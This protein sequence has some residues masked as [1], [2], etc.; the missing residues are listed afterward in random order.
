MSILENLNKKEFKLKLKSGNY[1]HTVDVKVSGK[2]LQLNFPYNPDL[3]NEVKT[4]FEGRKWLG[5]DDGPKAWQIPISPRNLFRLEVMSGKYTN[6]KPYK[7]FDEAAT[8]DCRAKILK[9]VESRNIN[10]MEHQFQMIS[11]ALI[12]K[13]F[14]WAAEMGLGKTLCSIIVM[15]MSGIQDWFWVAPRSAL[16]SAEIDFDKWK[17]KIRPRFMTYEGLKTIIEN[18]PV[19][20]PPPQG[21]IFDEV[22]RCKTPTAKRTIAAKYLADNMRM[23]YGTD[24]IIGGLS[25]TPAPKSPAD[26]WSLCELICPGFIKEGTIF[27]FRERLALMEKKE[28]LAGAGAYNALVT[29][30]D[31]EEKCKHCGQLKEHKNH[32]KADFLQSLSTKQTYEIHDWEPSVNEVA[33]LKKR[34][35]GLVGVWRKVDCLDLPL[36]RYEVIRV[37]PTR[38][39]KNAATIIA[40]TARRSVDA[41]TLLR[42][43]S[44]GFQY[45]D[46]PT[47]NML[48]CPCCNGKKEVIEYVDQDDPDNPL[49][50]DECAEQMRFVWSVC[51]PEDDVDIFIPE[52]IQKLPIT[53]VPRSVTCNECDGVGEV[54]EMHRVTHEVPCPKDQV[55]IDM[56]ERH[57]EV[58]R[59]NIYAGFQGSVDRVVKICLK[60]GWDVVRADGRGWCGFTTKGLKIETSDKELMKLYINDFEN[61]PQMVFVGQPGAA[62]MGLTL[63]VS[64]T[65]FFYSN[66]YN[67]ENRQQ[68]EDRGHRIGMDVERGGLI[69]DCFHLPSDE[70]VYINLR[71]KKDLQL[72]SL[73]G[74]RNKMETCDVE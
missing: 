14:L 37:K 10:P 19:G 1:Y 74:L 36:K 31:N 4:T 48:T 35:K 39:I 18:W 53:V 40:K 32:N 41:L 13:W 30:R 12:G 9:H 42:E 71:A 72:L 34:L 27:S 64:P 47:G 6:V 5:F 68:A 3:L 55:L 26:W 2:N 63:T 21:V 66:D 28:T 46:E 67:G 52:V 16:V 11:Q 56:L 22:S 70:D 49:S 25:G 43:L 57:E 54:K 45:K 7:Q 44:D 58:G 38:A 8:A 24:C 33:N 61:H 60:E 59:L 69:V 51:P 73:T 15:E 29:W 17:T 65:T 20:K 50:T 23:E 62:G